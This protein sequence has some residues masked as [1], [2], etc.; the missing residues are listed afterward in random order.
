L[1]VGVFNPYHPCWRF[2][3]FAVVV[4]ASASCWGSPPRK[5]RWGGLKETRGGCGFSLHWFNSSVFKGPH[6]FLPYLV[7][8]S[9]S[10]FPPSTPQKIRAKFS[11]AGEN[12]AQE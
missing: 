3:V 12:F 11:G 10:P 5:A 2:V 7:F 9:L 8:Q 4:F 1:R 6:L